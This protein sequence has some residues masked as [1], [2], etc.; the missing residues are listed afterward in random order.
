[1]ANNDIMQ[2]MSV[3]ELMAAHNMIVPEIQREYVWGFNWNG[4]LEI[5]IADIKGAFKNSD[6][7]K[8]T[9]RE[10]IK[11]LQHLMVN[12]ADAVKPL[13]NNQIVELEEK[14]QGEE[15]NIGFLYSYKPNYAKGESIDV[16]LIDGQQRFTTLFLLLF[17][18][19]IKEK[20]EVDFAKKFRFDLS[21]EKIAFDYRVRSNTHNFFM[22]LISKVNKVE[23]F[24]CISDKN[25]Y[26]ANYAND[27]TVRAM[28]GYGDKE[29]G[30][31]ALINESFKDDDG[32]YF[33]F[34][35]N[36]I[37]FWHFKTEDTSQ[38]EELYITMNSRGQQLADNEIIRAELFKMEEAV[39][40][41][42]KWSKK[43]EEWQDYFWEKRN[44]SEKLS[45]AD[46]GFNEF[47]RWAV[48]INMLDTYDA[49]DK[50]TDHEALLSAIL[51]GEVS[52]LPLRFLTLQNIDDTMEALKDYY[53]LFDNLSELEDAYPKLSG[54]D[55][56]LSE[57]TTG[58]HGT[59]LRQVDLFLLL[60]AMYYIMRRK[61]LLQKIGV[62]NLFRLIRYLFNVRKITTVTKTIDQQIINA[63]TLVKAIDESG[64][65]VSI[66]NKDKISTTLLSKEEVTKLT[67]FKNSQERTK[68]EEQYWK[69]EDF[70][71]DWDSGI[72]HIIKLSES[73]ANNLGCVNDSLLFE[74]LMDSF[75]E[76]SSNY[77]I[78][79][80]DFLITNLYRISNG[81][82]LEGW[83]WYEHD[84]FLQLVEE[85]FIN[86][87]LILYQLLE[88]KRKAFVQSYA[89]KEEM[90]KEEDWKRQLY[91]YYIISI[92]KNKW[93]WD[94]KFN[95]GVYEY[96]EVDYAMSLFDSG[97]VYERYSS[98][99]RFNV[100][101]QEKNG[102][103]LQ[104][105]RKKK[106]DY[107]QELIDW[108][109]AITN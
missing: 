20:R 102:L 81:R 50:N 56:L 18:F 51:R 65:I 21:L 42:V 96:D 30:A 84:S 7:G 73:I 93:Q 12:A 45:D 69:A 72:L 100:G 88:N 75:K 92:S 14:G 38:G 94:G 98:Q 70:F 44:K 53:C 83:N 107:F 79:W 68:L 67:N 78:S 25:W 4:I 55:I 6:S 80:G 86:D 104:D 74:G 63:F 61:N 8:S 46:N 108:A 95:F 57:E 37:R 35:L 27:T 1:M 39:Q 97:H 40:F 99:W 11:V 109:H 33:D 2:E 41:P 36:K 90:V 62:Q 87:D 24:D 22:D 49:R 43:W 71:S 76:I 105:H 101:Y 28:V 15:L 85:N 54:F 59:K 23:D 82:V 47:L 17:Y 10:Q 34:L 77:E 26:L 5:F 103:W 16:Y 13:I 66:L 3:A 48:L 31:F 89:S 91:L 106:H 64:D 58:V 32:K 52:K 29:K 19:S 60:P 9:I